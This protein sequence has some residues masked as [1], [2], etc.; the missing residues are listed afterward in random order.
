MED[1]ERFLSECMPA[2]ERFV[3]FKVNNRFDA[4]DILQET[5]ITAAQK[6]DTL[7]NPSA[8]MPWILRIARNKCTDYYRKQAKRLEIPLDVLPEPALQTGLYGRAEPSPVRDTLEL[9][10]DKDKQILYLS[11]FQHLPQAEI[12]ARLKIPVGTVKRRLYDAKRKFKEK[13]PYPPK[14]KGEPNM[15]QLP[16]MMPTYTITKSEKPPFEIR[17][18]EL[19]GMLIVP[20]KGETRSFAM[21]DHPQKKQSGIYHLQ[22]TGEVMIHDI[23]GV[24]ISS[25]YV[26]RNGKKEERAIFAQLTDSYCRYLGGMHTA[27]DGVRHIITFLDGDAFAYAYAIGENNCG[28]EVKRYPKGIIR[29]SANGLE[30]DASGDISDIVGRYTVTIDGK[31]YDTVRLIDM[32]AS[33]DGSCMLCEYYLD[34]NGRTVL[35]RRFNR[36]DWAF[37][38]YGKTWTE[39]LPVNETLPVN[40]Q[41][42][43]HW[44]DCITDYIL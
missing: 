44:Y 43:V 32:Q 19:P 7:Q 30:T 40:G 12:A 26:E 37:G 23:P 10:G 15:K 29:T 27:N 28:F 4:E 31:T 42:Y 22:V 17:H 33:N 24:E 18:E 39:M 25:Q 6:Q 2:L 35:W 21:Y 41:T 5:C 36:D 8:F 1:F 16:E 3:K 13:Y 11:Y 20:R 9:L 34:Q 14:T 38:R